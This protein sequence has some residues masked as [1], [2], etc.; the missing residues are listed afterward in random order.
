MIYRVE[1]TYTHVGR[2][3][4]WTRRLPKAY[5]SRPGAERAAR[6]LCWVVKP[7]GLIVVERS[8]ARVVEGGE[9]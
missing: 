7:D 3:V 1:Q 9:A 5:K 6:A 4:A 2:G 8:E